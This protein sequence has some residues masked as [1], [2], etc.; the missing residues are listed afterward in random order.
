MFKVEKKG[1]KDASFSLPNLFIRI[2]VHGDQPQ[3]GFYHDTVAQR[4]YIERRERSQMNPLVLTFTLIRLYSLVFWT[5][6]LY[7]KMTYDTPI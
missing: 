1:Q 2:M 7:R 5:V 4:R 6:A 3:L